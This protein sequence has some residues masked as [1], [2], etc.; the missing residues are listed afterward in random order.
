MVVGAVGVDDLV[1]QSTGGCGA[2][3]IERGNL[4]THRTRLDGAVTSLS[5]EPTTKSSFMVG[6]VASQRYSV[7]VATFTSELRATCHFGDIR[8]VTFPRGC[9]ELFVTA[10]VMELLR[11]RVP[12]LT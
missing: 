8:D 1:L 11:L 5:L 12:N 2:I 4:A 6:T 7:K 9:S 10:S 3:A